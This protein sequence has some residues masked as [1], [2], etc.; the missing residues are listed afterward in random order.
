MARVKPFRYGT[1]LRVRQHQEDLRAQALAVVLRERRLAERERTSISERQ[2]TTLQTAALTTGQGFDASETRHYMLF[3]RHL[4]RLS[5]EKDAEITQLKTMER[6]RRDALE[7][8]MKERRVI[9]RLKEKNQR[10]LADQTNKEMQ[11]FADEV[12]ISH[13]AMRRGGRR[14]P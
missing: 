11:K 12:A 3:E 2:L 7:Q 13:S 9:E 10:A 6:E 14:G 5:V 4:A 1:L 8:A